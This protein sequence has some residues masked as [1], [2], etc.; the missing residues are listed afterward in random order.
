ME[1]GMVLLVDSRRS[2][3]WLGRKITRFFLTRV[4]ILVLLQFFLERNLKELQTH[5]TYV[6]FHDIH[7][8]F[9]LSNLLNFNQ[10]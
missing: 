2:Q 3:G 4:L 8:F 7:L 1:A 10:L 5:F 9:N 6:K